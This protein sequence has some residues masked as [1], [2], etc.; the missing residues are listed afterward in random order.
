LPENK[1]K[2]NGMIVIDIPGYRKINAEHLVLDYNGTS[3]IDG[4]LIE[5]IREMLDKLSDHLKIHILTADTFGISEN[6]LS[7]IHCNLEILNMPYQD[8]QKDI[9]VMNLGCDNVIAIGNGM[10]DALMLKRAA[11]GIAVIQKEGASLKTLKNAD[12]VCNNIMDALELLINPL[13]V[14]ATLRK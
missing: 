12:L 2:N 6:E 1:K 11:L 5:G 9:Y 8:L 10:N 3:A 7:G 14:V 4:K 13:R